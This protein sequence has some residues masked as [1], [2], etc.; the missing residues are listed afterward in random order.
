MENSK[1]IDLIKTIK[2]DEWKQLLDFIDSP[3][4]NKNT[5]V[6]KLGGYLHELSKKNYPARPLQREVVWAAIFPQV[7]Y[8]QKELAYLMSSL[9]KLSERFLGQKLL[10]SKAIHLELYKLEALATRKL[11]KSYR[12]YLRKIQQGIQQSPL[13]D[14][15]HFRI[16][17]WLAEIE[18]HYFNLQN[19]RQ[20]N[21]HL[22][23]Q[24]QALDH[25]FHLS[26]IRLFCNMLNQQKILG[27]SYELSW[28]SAPKKTGQIPAE[29]TVNNTYACLY[30]LLMAADAPK[31]LFNQFRSSLPHIQDQLSNQELIS[32]YFFSINYCLLEINK[33]NREYATQLLV[34][35][36]D[37]LQ[38]GNLLINGELSPWIYKNIVKLGLGLKKFQWIEN[39]IQQ[40][41][42]QLPANQR[43]DAWHF[44]LADWHY[45]Q[46]A[47][48]EAL[49]WLNKVEFSDI[50]YKHGAK[51][52][53][54]KIYYANDATEAFLSLVTSYKILLTRDKALPED[55]R[56]NYQ[57]FV[58]IIDRLFKTSPTDT[59]GLEKVTALIQGTKK[60]AE[61]RW[62]QQQ[63]TLRKR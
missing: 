36:E 39:F 4:F 42:S 48:D 9:L 8:D 14:R 37:G 18:D 15:E 27:S 34:I 52:M 50:F 16:R 20:Y 57:N 24:N 63:V 45:H 35:Y 2:T 21:P 17:H 60:L 61:Q 46:Q 19:L 41:T 26:K 38:S 22:V 55:T 62:L 49:E 33:G 25:Y 56:T 40:Y 58:R 29:S 12:Q 43:H 6:S 11:D 44:N 47:Y 54:L 13:R 51:I 5:A 53:L 23:T 28:P 30:Q 1:L 7:A 59:P 32:L 3:Y 31:A 10:E